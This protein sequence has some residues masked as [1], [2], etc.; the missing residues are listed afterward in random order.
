VC[1]SFKAAAATAVSA[2]ILTRHLLD[3]RHANIIYNLAFALAART[4]SFRILLMAT[5]D[6]RQSGHQIQ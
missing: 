5:R 1:F 2:G 3:A 4:V 6:S